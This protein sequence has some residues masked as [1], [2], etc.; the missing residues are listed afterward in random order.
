[1][2]FL[3]EFYLIPVKEYRNNAKKNRSDCRKIIVCNIYKKNLQIDRAGLWKA[4]L[5]IRL[6]N[7]EVGSNASFRYS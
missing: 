6:P 4:I 1:M 7:W 2:L 5:H 3:T